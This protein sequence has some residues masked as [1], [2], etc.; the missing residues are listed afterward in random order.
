MTPFTVSTLPPGQWCLGVSGGGDS[1]ALAHLLHRQGVQVVWGHYNHRWSAWGDEAEML[2]RHQASQLSVA[3]QVG[4]GG[5]KPSSNAEAHARTE[6]QQFFHTLCQQHGLAGV[7]LAHTQ[8]DVAENFLLRAG[9]GSG[10]RGLAAMPAETVVNGLRILRPLL[11]VPREDLRAWLQAEKIAWLDD[12]DTSNQRAKIRALLPQLEAAGVPVHGLAAAA[13]ALTRA[14]AAIAAQV[15]IFL[16]TNPEKISLTALQQLP[17]EVA[18]Q[19]LGSILA[20]FTTG[21]VVRTSKRLA[22]L[23]KFHSQ[24]QGKATLGGLIWAW[25]AGRVQWRPE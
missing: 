20:R 4:Q 10:V 12:P 13:E 24:P 23:E 6:R 15:E 14:Q 22:L 7:I 21:P 8:T 5:G 3:L 1:L 2:V 25:Q 17:T 18:L 19:V 16:Q 11:G 9:K